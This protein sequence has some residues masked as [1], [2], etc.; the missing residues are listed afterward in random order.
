MIHRFLK[1]IK[2]RR[3]E[4]GCLFAPVFY[5]VTSFPILS[6]EMKNKNI[7]QYERDG[8]NVFKYA[9]RVWIRNAFK[10]ILFHHV[11]LTQ[12]IVYIH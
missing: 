10:Y 5:N 3:F 1:K 9:V 11:T 12:S 7:R 6:I 2:N 8:F 4:K